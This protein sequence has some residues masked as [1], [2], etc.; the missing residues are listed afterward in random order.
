MFLKSLPAASS[1]ATT[2]VPI[3][4]KGMQRTGVAYLQYGLGLNLGSYTFQLIEFGQIT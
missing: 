2:F 1:L 3:L 4:G